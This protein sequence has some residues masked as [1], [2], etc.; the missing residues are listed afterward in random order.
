MAEIAVN[1]R[2]GGKA[3]V[4]DIIESISVYESERVWAEMLIRGT[5]PDY[6][7]FFPEL[8]SKYFVQLRIIKM[9]KKPVVTYIL[10]PEKPS[11]KIESKSN[12][13]CFADK[14][15]IEFK[16]PLQNNVY[17]DIKKYFGDIKHESGMPLIE[18]FPFGNKA[19]K[20]NFIV[21]VPDNQFK[22]INEVKQVV[23]YDTD[24]KVKEY[25][26]NID[27]F[28]NAEELGISGKVKNL[29]DRKIDNRLKMKFENFSNNTELME[30]VLNP[31]IE[32][33]RLFIPVS[34]GII[35]GN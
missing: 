35:N 21:Y 30:L 20:R 29:K 3:K 5:H 10:N 24:K 14:Q 1:I 13:M 11:R 31:E 32:F 33:P 34:K 8:Y 26:T 9:F 23:K 16:T 4:N 6:D 18:T 19:L 17:Q 15:L 27:L 2:T 12:K 22:D 28:K 7:L 25:K